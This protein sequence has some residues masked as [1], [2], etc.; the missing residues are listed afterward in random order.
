[1]YMYVMI[2]SIIS[3]CLYILVT[4]YITLEAI[5]ENISGRRD[6]LQFSYFLIYEDKNIMFFDRLVKKSITPV[7]EL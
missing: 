7:C 4:G 3:Y 5:S 1:M 2:N 6:Q